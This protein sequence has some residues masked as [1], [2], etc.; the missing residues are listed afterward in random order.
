MKA[1]A[2]RRHLYWPLGECSNATVAGIFAGVILSIAVV[3]GLAAC[4]ASEGAPDTNVVTPT[5]SIYLAKMVTLDGVRCVVTVD[6]RAIS[7]DW[8]T[9]DATTSP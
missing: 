5:K 8:P 2:T 3:L 1:W 6:G 9:A 4:G 7:C